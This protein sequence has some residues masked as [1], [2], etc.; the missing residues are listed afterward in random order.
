[1]DVLGRV[2][3]RE[4]DVRRSQCGAMQLVLAAIKQ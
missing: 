2:T 4:S 1:M 3:P